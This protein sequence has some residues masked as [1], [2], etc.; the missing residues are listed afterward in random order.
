MKK[1]LS[2][3]LVLVLCLSLCACGAPP[4]TDAEMVDFLNGLSENYGFNYL[5]PL[6]DAKDTL[7]KCQ[8]TDNFVTLIQSQMET[9]TNNEDI[10]ELFQLV[11]NLKSCGYPA[12]DINAIFDQVVITKINNTSCDNYMSIFK[13]IGEA[14]RKEHY[15]EAVKSELL[16]WLIGAREYIFSADLETFITYFEEITEKHNDCY[17]LPIIECFPY[18]ELTLYLETNGMVPVRTDAIGGYYDSIKEDF[19][20]ESYWYSP[21]D[22]HKVTSGS[23]GT[24]KYSKNHVFLGDFLCVYT[25]KKW[26]GTDSSDPSNSSYSTGF[27][28]GIEI[29]SSGQVDIDY[30]FWTATDVYVLQDGDTLLIASIDEDRIVIIHNRDYNQQMI[31][32][33]YE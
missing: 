3:I 9:L 8:K 17:Y 28:K 4:I 16:K 27:Y 31:T 23:V 15:S 11:K 13:L 6:S 30:L 21:L 2:L 33:Q 12:E 32:I 10:T 5:F 25:S 26:Y 14:N 19:V 7:K 1:A 22:G 20:D 24:Y 29:G 18:Q